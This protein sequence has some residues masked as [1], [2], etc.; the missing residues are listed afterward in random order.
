[1][2]V[3]RRALAGVRARRRRQAGGHRPGRARRR[4]RRKQYVGRVVLAGSSAA[5]AGRGEPRLGRRAV[6]PADRHDPIRSTI[7]YRPYPL[8][9]TAGAA[10]DD[11]RLEI[12]ARGKGRFRVG[13]VSL[14]PADNVAGHAG[15]HAGAAPRAQL[16]GLP[17]ARRQLRQRLQLE[18]RHRRPR[19]AAAAQEPGVEGRR[20]Q[21]RRHRRVHGPLP[22]ARHRALH[23]RQ[24]RPGRRRRR[25]PT[26][27]E[28]A[29]GAATTP[30]GALRAQNGHAGAVRVQL[31]G[32]RQR[33]VRRLAARP[34]AARRSTSKKHNEFADAMRATDPS[35]KLVAVGDVGRVEPRRCCRQL[36]GPHDL[37]SEHFYVPG[38]AGPAWATWRR[39]RGSI[40]RI[41][42]AH[43]H[44]RQTIPALA[45]QGHPHRARRVELLVRAARLRR[46]RHALLPQGRAGH[47]GRPARVLPP[48]R[49]H[50][51]GQLRADGQ[52]DRRDQ[53]HEDR[54]RAST[55]RASC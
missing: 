11:A 49:H 7:D 39:C 4:G 14:M 32:D 52:R 8:A 35:I 25:R 23:R 13:T 10:T 54:G 21:R 43:R 5:R 42:D 29:N 19:P 50:L 36:R 24:Q 48:E 3:R 31:V 37:I 53:D 18:R 41:A 20:A 33:D 9:F 6:E 46:A 12:A 22:P 38:G 15:R 16:A 51:H 1:M 45:G 17:L 47:R 55:R 27:V 44:Y 40:Q 26:Q 28:Y 34:H 2:A 30:M